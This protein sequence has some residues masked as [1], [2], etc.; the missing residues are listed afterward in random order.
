MFDFTASIGI[1]AL[2]ASVWET[3]GQDVTPRGGSDGPAA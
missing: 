3:F 2:T 1:Q